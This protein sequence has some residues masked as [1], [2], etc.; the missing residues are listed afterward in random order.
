MLAELNIYLKGNMSVDYW[1]DEALFICEEL[2]EKF[3]DDDWEK[4]IEESSKESDEWKK[5]LVECLGY[6]HNS[7][8]LRIILNFINTDNK[9]LF[10]ACVDSLRSMDLDDLDKNIKMKLINEVKK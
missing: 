9:D 10:I 7:Y 3:S 1:Y 4:L 2:L 6:L 5:R 8:E